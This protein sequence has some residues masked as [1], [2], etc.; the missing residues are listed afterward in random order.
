MV[1]GPTKKGKKVEE[2][3]VIGQTVTVQ[4]VK[5]QMVSVPDMCNVF[6]GKCEEAR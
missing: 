6:I 3:A 4:V 2:Q 1:E 5:G